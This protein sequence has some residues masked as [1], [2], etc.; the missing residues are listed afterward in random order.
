MSNLIVFFDFDE[1]YIHLEY[2]TFYDIVYENNNEINRVLEFLEGYDDH[3]DE[4]K[5]DIPFST[6][7]ILFFETFIINII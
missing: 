1:E 3:Y 6:C 2:Y 7:F 4:I 5:N